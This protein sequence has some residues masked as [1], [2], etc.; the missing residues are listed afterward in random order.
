M[1][2]VFFSTLDVKTSF[3]GNTNISNLA[4]MYLSGIG[5]LIRLLSGV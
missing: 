3:I 1:L 2:D 5:T 4:P